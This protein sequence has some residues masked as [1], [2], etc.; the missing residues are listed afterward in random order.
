LALELYVETGGELDER[1]EGT[2][3]GEGGSAM[4]TEEGTR[5]HALRRLPL[6]ATV[7]PASVTLVTLP[8]EKDSSATSTIWET[9]ATGV[10]TALEDESIR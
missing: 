3:E 2:T 6:R 7:K 9:T 10:S 1:I 4:R 8:P 5:T